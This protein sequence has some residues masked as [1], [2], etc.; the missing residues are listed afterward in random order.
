MSLATVVNHAYDGPILPNVI[1]PS[2]L[3]AVL[4]VLASTN[5]SYIRLVSPN[6]FFITFLFLYLVVVVVLFRFGC[7]HAVLLGQV[8]L[9]GT[10]ASSISSNLFSLLP[11]P[12]K[13]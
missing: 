10:D 3:A 4:A 8:G 13:I 1:L 9:R 11:F 6:I 2:S 12:A 7:S 5:V